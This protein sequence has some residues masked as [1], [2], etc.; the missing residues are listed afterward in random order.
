VLAGQW[1]ELENVVSSKTNQTQKDK[2]VHVS[3]TC[4][5]RV[6]IHTHVHLHMQIYTYIY[7]KKI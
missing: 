3:L 7:D 1:A 2:I 5:T 4:E 6:Y